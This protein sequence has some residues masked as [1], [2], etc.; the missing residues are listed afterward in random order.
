MNVSVFEIT[1][2][3]FIRT[4]TA[5]RKVLVKAGEFAE[6]KKIQPEVLLA[7]R[8]APDQFPL[9]R[10][11]QIATDNAK[12][13]VGRLTNVDMPKFEDKEITLDQFLDR[14]DRTV[15]FLK[16]AKP[17]QFNGYEKCTVRFPWYP[18]NFMDGRT[19]LVQHAI[20]NFYFHV[21][22]AYS[23]LRS[24]GLEI[25]KGDYLGAQDWQKE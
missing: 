24:C 15:A 18:G 12:G 21:T 4:L 6:K 13:C 16:T 2:P 23:I 14:I 20:P 7:T 22:T 19:Y 25:G 5:L 1:A 10:Q 9:S 17:E 8:L 11:I 3:Q